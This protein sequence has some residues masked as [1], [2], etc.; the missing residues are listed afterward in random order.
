[1]A[2]GDIFNRMHQNPN[3]GSIWNNNIPIGDD[4]KISKTK[5]DYCG[6]EVL[7]IWDKHNSDNW[8]PYLGNQARKPTSYKYSKAIQI[9]RKYFN[10][11]GKVW[12]E[13]N[14]NNLMN[15]HARAHSKPNDWSKRAH[16]NGLKILCNSCFQK[17]YR[18]INVLGD[19]GILYQLSVMP[20][21][22]IEGV[23]NDLSIKGKV[24]DG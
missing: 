22:T 6:K 19:N 17:T 7:C 4:T 3:D 15:L 5:C 12:N 1:M 13:E 9:L 16:P 20:W 10:V 8:Y 18:R 24:L 2:W 21:E 14:G 23:M 11:E